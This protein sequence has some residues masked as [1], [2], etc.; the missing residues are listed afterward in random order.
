[1]EK[2]KSKKSVGKRSQLAIKELGLF[3]AALILLGG[4]IYYVQHGVAGSSAFE[5]FPRSLAYNVIEQSGLPQSDLGPT[6]YAV[7]YARPGD[8]ISMFVTVKNLS[9]NSK[10]LVWYPKKDLL[11]EGIDYPSAHAIGVGVVNDESPYWVD[12]SSFVINGNRL[13][14]YDG[15]A[16]Y[17]NNYMTISWQIKISQYAPYGVYTLDLGLLREF[18]EWGMR[19]YVNG[20]NSDDQFIR[21]VFKVSDQSI[22]DINTTAIAGYSP[23]IIYHSNIYQ[24]SNQ[25]GYPIES[26]LMTY[27]L[28]TGQSKQI[29]KTIEYPDG[30]W[31]TMV[32]PY[33]GKIKVDLSS[34]VAGGYT[35]WQILDIDGNMINFDN[36]SFRAGRWA[37]MLYSPDERYIAAS[38]SMSSNKLAVYDCTTNQMREY[39]INA[40]A[41]Y[42]I[43]GWSPDSD[44]V[45]VDAYTTGWFNNL[46]INRYQ[47][48]VDGNGVPE[49]MLWLN[50]NTLG[51]LSMDL[52]NGF[53]MAQELVQN[54]FSTPQLYKYPRELRFIDLSRGLTQLINKTKNSYLGYQFHRMSPDGSLF[55][56]S[57]KTRTYTPKILTEPASQSEFGST[58]MISRIG[59]I[60]QP[61]VVSNFGADVVGWS[62]DNRFVAYTYTNTA[63]VSGGMDWFGFTVFDLQ[64]KLDYQP[65]IADNSRVIGIF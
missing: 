54:N 63:M 17:K 58:L 26:R 40:T 41:G 6:S 24:G 8:T 33:H 39:W 43:V 56:Y 44:R 15:P 53:A 28:V 59:D 34:Y 47:I 5:Q 64:Y 25:Q 45:F 7:H 3:L 10:A 50:D 37:N 18:D 48:F 55:A 13:A 57:M 31:A 20:R 52:T 1:M 4:L 35:D 14:Y 62:K 27:D 23:K 60:Y 42:R 51:P 65:P 21:W 9:R 46:K 36:E 2:V 30:I 32:D 16:V 61:V 49:M 38:D 19:T 12:P 11:D 29:Y 22:Y